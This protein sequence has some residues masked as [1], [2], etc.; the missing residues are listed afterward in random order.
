MA[1]NGLFAKELQVVNVGL[2]LFYD[3]LQKAGCKA[4]QTQWTIP[5]SADPRIKALLDKFAELDEK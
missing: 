2:E 1:L 3:D 5:T 4:I